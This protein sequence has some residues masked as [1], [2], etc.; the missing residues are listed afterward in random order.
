MIL[1]SSAVHEIIRFNDS[2]ITVC[3]SASSHV[4]VQILAYGI[5]INLED[6]F[7]E[8]GIDTNNIPHL[9]IDL[10][11]QWRHGSIEVNSIEEL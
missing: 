11:F 10:Q 4:S 3:S 9:M 8:S 6:V 5:G 2:G 1:E 7:V